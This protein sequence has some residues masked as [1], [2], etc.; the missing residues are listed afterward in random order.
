MQ[1]PV[2]FDTIRWYLFGFLIFAVVGG[3][4]LLLTDKST[5]HLAINGFY[6][7]FFDTVAVVLTA[8]GDGWAPTALVVVFLFIQFRT[9]L[10]IAVAS[11][12][13][14]ILTQ[15]LKHTVFAHAVRPQVFFEHIH[16][17]RF[18]PGVELF[19]YNSFP[20]GHAVTAVAMC[21]CLAVYFRRATAQIA[22]LTLALLI[23]FSR[24][25]LSQHFF[26]DI[27]GGAWIGLICGVGSAI[28]LRVGGQQPSSAWMDQSL[29]TVF[30]RKR[31]PPSRP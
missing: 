16:P 8:L 18:V 9:A 13:G 1:R 28:L 30:H 5:L 17:L 23:A 4:I 26:G 14:L 21:L 24:V 22:F 6:S 25:Y 20:S 11:I 7:P 29:L 19:S 10:H 15:S 2:N 3:A 31:I 12:A 27:Y